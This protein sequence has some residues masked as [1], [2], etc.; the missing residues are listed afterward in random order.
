M[1]DDNVIFVFK[2]T[3][4]IAIN[5]K[6]IFLVVKKKKKK[7]KKKN[8]LPSTFRMSLRIQPKKKKKKKK[9]LAR[10]KTPRVKVN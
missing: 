4:S 9:G 8:L 7:K 2:H 1:R 10:P 3:I 5:R 6:P